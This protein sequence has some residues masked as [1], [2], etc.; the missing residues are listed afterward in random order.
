MVKVSAIQTEVK[1]ASQMIATQITIMM[2]A[3]VSQT[4]A[5]VTMGRKM[6]QGHAVKTKPRSAVSAIHS[7]ISTELSVVQMF[8]IASM[9]LQ[10]GKVNAMKTEVK[11]VNQVD[12]TTTTVTMAIFVSRTFVPVIMEL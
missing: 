4:F 9:E 5:L 6:A 8:V 11:S 10:M 3:F 1:S 7:I 12:A 2:E